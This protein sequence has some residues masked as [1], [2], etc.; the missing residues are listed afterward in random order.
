VTL[1]A[2]AD[3]VRADVDAVGFDGLVPVGCSPAGCWMPGIVDRLRARVRHLVF[4]ACT[5]PADGRSAFD[6]LDADVRVSGVA[7]APDAR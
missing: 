3:A 6:V 2:C 1:G 5:V 4:V 7:S